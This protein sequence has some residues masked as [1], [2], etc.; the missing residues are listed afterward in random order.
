MKKVNK[1]PHHPLLVK[2]FSSATKEACFTRL[3]VYELSINNKQLECFHFF[4][5]N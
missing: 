3:F 1:R 2:M 5:I 4:G